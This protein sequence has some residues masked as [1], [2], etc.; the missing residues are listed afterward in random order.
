M[1]KIYTANDMA[2][3]T[4]FDGHTARV[5]ALSLA[6]FRSGAIRYAYTG[7]VGGDPVAARIDFGRWIAD[8]PDCSGAEYVDYDDPVFFCVSC[9]NEDNEG[10]A[11][12]VVF[13]NEAER[14]EIEVLILAR[15]V[16][17]HGKRPTQRALMAA[18]V[19]P[20]LG[21]SWNPG[22]S[23]ADLKRQNKAIR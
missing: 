13:P 10:K 3:E 20:G 2:R 23:A 1:D 4:G 19:I 8:C 21:R 7:K 6:A 15:P 11:R 14:A 9:G 18:P 16:K 5:K 22:E 17:A 12:P